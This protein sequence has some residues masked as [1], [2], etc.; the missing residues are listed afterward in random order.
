MEIIPITPRSYCRG[1]VLAI[2]KAI[3]TKRDHQDQEVYLLGK[4]VH[5]QLVV[6]ALERNGVKTI[7][8]PGKSREELLDTI[9]EG[10]VVF[11]AHGVSDQVKQKAQ[12]KGLEIVDATCPEVLFTD[13]LVLDNINSGKKVLYIG[14]KGHPEATGICQDREGVYLIESIEEIPEGLEGEEIFVTNQTTLSIHAL[15]HIFDAIVQKYPQ[16]VITNEICSATRRRQEA[17]T[18]HLD[19]D[20]LLVI[21]DPSSNNTA[22]LAQI[23]EES[24]I[25]TVKRVNALQE[26]DL[27]WFRDDSRVGVTAGASTPPY[28]IRQLEEY[29][30]E[31]D[32]NN[33]APYPEVDLDKLL[34]IKG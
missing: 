23:G 31:V 11:S 25:S 7:D 30:A 28:L 9:T 20:I 33:P 19:I 21:G 29:L 22:M 13:K 10:I 6:D 18:K 14:K 2:Q 17:I 1:V 3:Q 24:G 16:A 32:L 27:A 4:I 26:V 15:A 8:I 34:E 12:A 5:N